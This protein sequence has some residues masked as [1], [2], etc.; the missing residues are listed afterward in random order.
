V[1]IDILC[2]RN[3]FKSSAGI[4]NI[5][6]NVS[7][8]LHKAGHDIRIITTDI[9]THSFQ[10]NGIQVHCFKTFYGCDAFYFSPWVYEEMKKSDADFVHCF[11]YNNLVTPAGLLC[12][13]KRQKLVV[14]LC[15]S[16]SSSFFRKLLWIPY[17]AFFFL[18]K[19]RVDLFTGLSE[20]E[21]NYF[22]K[23][24]NVPASRMSVIPSGVDL[25]RVRSVPNPKKK[26]GLIISAG[27]LVKNKG[28]DRIIKAL[29]WVLKQKHSASLTILGTG[30]EKTNLEKLAQA[31]GIEKNVLL[32]GQIG[33]N[34][35]D[36]YYK[37][38]KE[39]EVF[40][41]LSD[42]E[43]QG[44]VVSEAIACGLPVI[45]SNNSGF[46]DFVKRKEAIGLDDPTDPERVA[47]TIIR[48]LDNPEKFRPT[49][50]F[51]LDWKAVGEKILQAYQNIY[52]SK[53][54]T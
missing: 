23:L 18:F 45:V 2:P 19:K 39:A 38:L 7:A 43:S 31:L 24:L 12:K 15:S 9:T 17:T 28:F 4:E 27:R 1:K 3:P 48:V 20:F 37:R 44:I 8:S 36:L 42:Y 10:Q 16:G 25:E 40:V 51:V 35:R 32:A 29:P 46:K 53:V 49:N 14:S 54:K 22:K 41:F 47:K 34:D 11:G 21:A 30:E 6:Q 52:P 26:K 13:K 50:K 5:V 33:L